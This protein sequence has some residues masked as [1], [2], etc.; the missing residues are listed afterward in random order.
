MKH[1]FFD[2]YSYLDSPVHRFNPKLKILIFL[3]IAIL[4]IAVP[5]FHLGLYV[6]LVVSIIGLILLSKVPLSFVLKRT[7]V[8]VPIAFIVALSNF[9]SKSGDHITLY[10]TLLNSCIIVAMLIL[11]VETTRFPVILKSLAQLKVPSLILILLSFIYRYFFVLIDE[12]ERMIYSI[13]VRT[14]KRPDLKTISTIVAMVFVKSYERAERIYW[15]MIL[16]GFKE[17]LG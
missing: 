15:A 17:D 16:R 8:I 7:A 12:I 10:K 14:Y 5:G 2:K 4:V 1:S 6:F 9:L 3:A 11:V 13:K